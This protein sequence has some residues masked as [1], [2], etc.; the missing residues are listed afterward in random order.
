LSDYERLQWVD[1]L[2]LFTVMARTAETAER[3][4]RLRRDETIIPD[5]G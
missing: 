1:E 3:Q 5:N 4:E 2:R